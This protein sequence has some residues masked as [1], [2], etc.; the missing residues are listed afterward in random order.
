[1]AG[2]T[3]VYAH[4][5]APEAFRSSVFLVG[6]T[7]TENGVRSWRT[8]ALRLL[9]KAGYEGV[10]FVPEKRPDAEGNTR[11]QID[12]TDQ[13]EWEFAHL[14]LAD[15]ILAWVDRTP[16]NPGITTNY[17]LG[18]HM[19]SGKVVF[20]APEDSWKTRYP[21]YWAEKRQVPIAFTLEKTVENALEMLGEGILRTGGERYIPPYIW[22]T[23]SFQQWYKNLQQAGN[24]LDYAEVVWSW[25]VG[26]H[27]KLTFFWILHAK[28]WIASEKRYKDNEVVL[29]RPDV[30]VTV[31]YKRAT[32]LDDCEL[33][34][35][36]EFRT[37]VSNPEGYVYENAGGSSWKEST[38]PLEGASDEVHEETGIS[39][40][41]SRFV[42]HGARQIAPTIS[43]HQ[44]HLF[45]AELTN[46][47]MAQIDTTTPHGVA[48]DTE[49]TFALRARVGDIR[50]QNLVGWPDLG[51]ILHVLA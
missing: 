14:H 43:A 42:Y 10:V 36:K 22:K 4:E 33:I 5:K 44:A 8:D 24:R 35:V 28:I 40:A 30:S 21:R 7:P 6:P 38:D 50:R 34:L 47:E 3:V 39:I 25:R 23:D 12:Y 20:G 26:P 46:E 41:P 29:A 32:T 27:R 48:E 45:S 16:E 9:E 1:M 51:M 18:E 37:P 17:E 49:R 15:V 13:V 11:F 31:L 19:D 2:M